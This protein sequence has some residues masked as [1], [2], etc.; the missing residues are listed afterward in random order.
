MGMQ[1]IR[2][3][4]LFSGMDTGSMVDQLMRAE[5]MRLERFTR[6]RTH[7]QWQQEDLRTTSSMLKDFRSKQVAMNTQGTLMWPGEWN[8][9]RA[10]ATGNNSQATNGGLTV[11]STGSANVGQFTVTVNSSARTHMMLGN[12]LTQAAG[13]GPAINMQTK[14]HEVMGFT[15]GQDQTVTLSGTNGSDIAIT[16]N[17]DMTI[18]E[19]MNHINNFTDSSGNKANATIKYDTFHGAFALEGRSTGAGNDVR[20]VG[21]GGNFFSTLGFVGDPGNGD[22]AGTTS[23]RY[24]R[25]ASDASITVDNGNGPAQTFT[26]SGN[27]FSVLGVSIAITGA[28]D[29]AEYTVNNTRNVDDMVDRIK[30]FVED[31][32]TILRTLNGLHSTPRPRTNTGNY[33][34]P[35]TDDKRKGMSDRDIERWEQAARTGLL[36]RDNELRGLHSDI[37]SW[38]MTDVKLSDGRS[39]N[40]TSIGVTTGGGNNSERMIGL[41]QIDEDQLR[42]ALTENPDDVREMFT[43]YDVTVHPNTNVGRSEQLPGIGL[44]MRLS[45]LIDNATANEDSF[46]RRRAGEIGG[47][48][49]NSNILSDQIRS[50][51]RRIMD[52]ERMLMRREN[53]FYS[54]FA[55]M[56]QAMAKS[57]SQMDSLM[58]FGAQM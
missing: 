20:I 31:Y 42:R 56:E 41:L 50:L 48:D 27:S 58:M 13:G 44:A 57:N 40:L 51:D 36:N 24:S 18:E 17:G 33:Y 55:R 1:P 25:L 19:A 7:A 28:Q 8:T 15:P 29:G 39:I 43:S 10:T 30:S 38:M 49:A 45:H 46:L 14:L 23:G 3:T 22:Q 6:Q 5:R 37:R 2:F 16:L 47:Q 32:N 53:H 11:N 4:G 9:M 21:D 34:D 26:S 12:D 54:M 35:L 52:M